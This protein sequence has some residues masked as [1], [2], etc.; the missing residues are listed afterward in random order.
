M[1]A[2]QIAKLDA[3]VAV[4]LTVDKRLVRILASEALKTTSAMRLSVHA[5]TGPCVSPD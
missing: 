2:L 4:L 1:V 5:L 3:G